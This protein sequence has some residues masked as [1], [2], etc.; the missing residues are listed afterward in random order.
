MYMRRMYFISQGLEILLKQ[1]NAHTFL[2]SFSIN[3]KVLN[4]KFIYLINYV[5]NMRFL[6]IPQQLKTGFRMNLE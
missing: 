6:C 5:M 1:K 2:L 4:N 3:C